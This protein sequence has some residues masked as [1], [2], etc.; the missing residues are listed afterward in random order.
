[1]T[2]ECYTYYLGIR[3]TEELT[4]KPIQKRA[5]SLMEKTSKSFSD[6]IYGKALEDVLTENKA[7]LFFGSDLIET[8]YSNLKQWEIIGK[9]T[10]ML[11]MHEVVRDFVCFVL[12]MMCSLSDHWNLVDN[13]IT[14]KNIVFLFQA[15]CD[16]PK[17]FKSY[18]QLTDILYKSGS[19]AQNAYDKFTEIIRNGYKDYV[20]SEA[21]VSDKKSDQNV[22][23]QSDSITKT[24][25]QYLQ[26]QL[27]TVDQ[28]NSAESHTIQ[29]FKIHT[30]SDLNLDYNIRGMFSSMA[31]NFAYKLENILETDDKIHSTT[32]ADKMSD[33][34]KLALL[35]DASEHIIVGSKYVLSPQ[36]Y[37][38][39]DEYQNTLETRET[40]KWI[41][42]DA[43]DVFMVITQGRLSVDIRKVNVEVA[44]EPIDSYRSDFNPKTGLYT[45]EVSVGMKVKFT[46]DELREYLGNK[47]R[48]LIISVEAGIQESDDLEV[49]VYEKTR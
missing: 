12:M 46:E 42:Q 34:Q 19:D 47:R 6:Y 3:E 48:L 2:T 17:G 18:K 39:W 33:E 30:F 32:N 20:L 43:S 14:D 29:L 31:F 21:A 27:N 49:D 16:N 22:K 45:C 40:D 5:T 15:F 13:I 44:P 24:V 25:L 41:L 36:S 38:L 10:K 23:S 1:M 11:I 9:D 26:S 28:P 7:E 4:G 8:I 35:K 37:S